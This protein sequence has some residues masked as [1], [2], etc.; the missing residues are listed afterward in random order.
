MKGDQ[1]LNRVVIS[2]PRV[3]DSAMVITQD[4][5]LQISTGTIPPTATAPYTINSIQAV[6]NETQLSN[7]LITPLA[8]NSHCARVTATVTIP[9]TVNL[10]DANNVAFQ[11]NTSITK[12]INVVLYIPDNTAFPY[13]ITAEGAF[14]YDSATI[15]GDTITI[16]CAVT[17]IL[18]RVT[19][20]TD[21]LV[22]TYG[23]APMQQADN[24]GC[25]NSQTF[26]N[27]PL[28]PQGKVY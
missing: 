1:N 3:L 9:L 15:D 27:Q 17:K 2:V 19:A 14:G 26:L 12:N 21:L 23:Y 8:D 13:T 5:Q 11:T 22:P 4:A 24:T 6:A 28:F 20:I 16:L 18:I 10:T 7:L 25:S